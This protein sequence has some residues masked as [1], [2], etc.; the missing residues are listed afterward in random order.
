MCDKFQHNQKG[1]L[2]I[3]LHPICVPVVGYMW[4]ENFFHMGG[5]EGQGGKIKTC[6]SFV[7]E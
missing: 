3:L 1:I 7:V 4:N 5:K 2:D 6:R